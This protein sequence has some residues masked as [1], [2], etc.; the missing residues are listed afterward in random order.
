MNRYAFFYSLKQSVQSL[1]RNLWLAGITSGLIAISLVIL[2]GFL[3]LTVNVNQFMF[4]IQSNV[5][6]GVFLKDNV[7]IQGVKDKI[8]AIPDVVS[9][10]Y[11]PKEQGLKDFAKTLG[12]PTLVK[13]LEGENNPIPDL[14]RVKVSDPE[15][16]A[17]VAQSLRLYPEV[18]MVD[19]GEELVSKVIQ[20]T[21][22]LNALFLALSISI[23]FGAVFLIVTIIR[24]SVVARQEEVT[25]MK[26]LGAS[27]NY[28]KF[29]FLMEGMVMGWTGTLLAVIVLALLYSQ[30]VASLKGDALT[31]LFQPVTD[32]GRILPIFIGLSVAGT[33][34]GGFG[35]I[36]S[37]RKYLR[38]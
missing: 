37:I 23:G 34:V 1:T 7:D 18:E 11:I 4:N 16:V 12:D 14:I 27:D 19:Y 10:S 24:L 35:S 36:I 17:S 26:Y 9:Y 5:E 13:D 2:G 8:S 20:I 38:V 15:K 22:K 29:P 33:I 32:S 31:L 28:I 30:L 3:L 21:R 6:I 25:V